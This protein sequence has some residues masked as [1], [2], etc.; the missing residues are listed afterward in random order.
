MIRA[1]GIMTSGKRFL[2][3]GLDRENIN[4]L[5]AGQP[6]NCDGAS[7]EM[8]Y[9]T[10]IMFAETTEELIETVAEMGVIK[11]RDTPRRPF[12]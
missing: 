7:V 1:S 4:R 12:E 2:L 10:I 5:T 11:P 3:L 8:P 6:I 9:D